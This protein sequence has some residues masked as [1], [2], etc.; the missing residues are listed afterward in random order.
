M[1]LLQ[2]NIIGNQNDESWEEGGTAV[3]QDI[4]LGL[5]SDP[6]VTSESGGYEVAEAAISPELSARRPG[7]TMTMES[8]ESRCVALETTC[9]DGELFYDNF[10]ATNDDGIGLDYNNDDYGTSYGVEGSEGENERG[11]CNGDNGSSNGGSTKVGVLSLRMRRGDLHARGY[12]K[13]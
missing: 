3:A 1:L 12:L 2:G 4:S 6:F 5:T 11:D 9:Q 8:S 10:E 13:S 7:T